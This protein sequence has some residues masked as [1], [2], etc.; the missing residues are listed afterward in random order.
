MH[1]HS[2]RNEPPATL[3]IEVEEITTAL[4]GALREAGIRL[5]Q[6]G[7][8]PT[9]VDRDWVVRLGDCNVGVG[10]K[11]LNLVKDGLTLRKNHPEEAAA[12]D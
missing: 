2:T 8:R 10:L 7:A 11:L 4:D 9:E 1:P 5:P 12:N 3:V 6:F